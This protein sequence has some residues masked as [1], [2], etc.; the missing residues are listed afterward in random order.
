MWPPPAARNF[1]RGSVT[2]CG[3]I[4]RASHPSAP[5]FHSNVHCRQVSRGSRGSMTPS[6]APTEQHLV[7][8]RALAIHYSDGMPIVVATSAAC[9][10]R[11]SRDSFQHG[12]GRGCGGI[13]YACHP[14][15]SYCHSNLRRLQETSGNRGSA[16]SSSAKTAHRA[17]LPRALAIRDGAGIPSFVTIKVE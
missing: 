7:S 10:H 4:P 14:P 12:S 8:P 15:A 5:Y 9:G 16:A 1:Q 2:S 3:G 13:P 6:S 11:Q 17:A